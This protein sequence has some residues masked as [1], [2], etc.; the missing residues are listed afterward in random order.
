MSWT[1]P[2]V[3]VVSRG[4]VRK[5]TEERTRCLYALPT[6]FPKSATI[7]DDLHRSRQSAFVESRHSVDTCALFVL[8]VRSVASRHAQAAGFVDTRGAGLA[9][10]RRHHR[11]SSSLTRHS[12]VCCAEQFSCTC[13]VAW[14]SS[15]SSRSACPR[16][17]IH[18]SCTR[19]PRGAPTPPFKRVRHACIA[20]TTS[21]HW[22]TLFFLC[23]PCPASLC[24]RPRGAQTDAT[25]CDADSDVSTL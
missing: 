16:R 4:D 18:S 17:G 11:V 13:S 12:V 3:K 1:K 25:R 10:E 19:R 2:A 15:W 21:L 5:R 8:V 7:I 22:R 23:F 20:R 6:F 9:V 14:P 24:S